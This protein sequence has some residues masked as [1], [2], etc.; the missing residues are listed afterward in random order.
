MFQLVSRQ[1][2]IEKASV[3]LQASPGF[4]V[5]EETFWGLFVFNHL[6]IPLLVTHFILSVYHRRCTTDLR[7][8]ERCFLKHISL[9]IGK[10]EVPLEQSWKTQR[11]SRAAT[12]LFPS[13][14]HYVRVG[15]ER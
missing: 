5:H 2:F 8:L 1:P 4:V 15:G 9:S 7:N 11:A 14:R 13:P 10:S 3:S 6:K 12:L